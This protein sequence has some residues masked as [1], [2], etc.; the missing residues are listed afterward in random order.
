MS[1]FI[2]I[3]GKTFGKL[4]VIRL[5]GRNSANRLTWKCL[6]KCGS[7]T[8]ATSNQLKTGRKLSCGCSKKLPVGDGSLNWV[9]ASYKRGA[10]YRNLE[11]SLDKNQFR[12]ITS[13][14]CYYCGASPNNSA[15]YYK[16]NGKYIYNGIDRIDNKKG[17]VLNNVVPCCKTCNRAKSIHSI[18]DFSN[19][20][21][22]VYSKMIQKSEFYRFHHKTGTM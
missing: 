9:F 12:N 19:W 5:D 3:S 2:D 20:I 10:K 14:P 1:K 17:Y 13:Q 21:I 6:C 22:R 16:A 8:F 11:F 4:T 15:S 18:D 7:Y